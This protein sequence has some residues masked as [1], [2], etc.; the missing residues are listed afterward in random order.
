MS[1][2]RTPRVDNLWTDCER[3]RRGLAFLRSCERSVLILNSG[4]GVY[5]E[6]TTAPRRA[7]R[8]HAR[9]NL[10]RDLPLFPD[11]GGDGDTVQAVVETPRGS[12]L[13]LKYVP[14]FDRFAW[15]RSLS[16]GVTFPYD[17]GFL[18]QTLAEDGEAVD[19]VVLADVGSFP[20][21]IVPARIVGALRVL[22]QRDGGPAKRNDRVVVV[23]VN[24]HRHRALAD[25]G[26]LPERMRDE[27]E[28]FFGAS[29]LLTGKRV[30][31]RGWSSAAEAR[32][33]V[34]AAHLAWTEAPA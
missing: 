10:L 26:D 11:T 7:L 34:A 30:E 32:D 14:A 33:A 18:P 31:F 23:P 1:L 5:R 4:S 2:L 22:Q 3:L 9:V 19:A 25:V 15:S 17:Y 27:L 28:A 12:S 21:V 29:L 8:Y 24:E 6:W 13:K 16:L 20:G